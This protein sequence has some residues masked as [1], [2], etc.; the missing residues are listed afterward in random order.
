MAL[1]PDKDPDEFVEEAVRIDPTNL[2]QE[3]IQLPSQLAYFNNRYAE[4]YR[5]WTECKAVSEQVAAQLAQQIRDHLSATSKGRVTLAEVDQQVLLDPTYRQAKAKERV[6]EA[7]K[8]R[9]YGVMDAL[10]TKR[11]MLISL[12]ANYRLEM[13]GD[14]MLRAQAKL[15]REVE[16]ARNGY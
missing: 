16:H 7:E 11:D 4:V 14:P 13:S 15:E 10:R 2:N 8:V 6:A 12:G 1:Y 5:Y 9:L 3:Y